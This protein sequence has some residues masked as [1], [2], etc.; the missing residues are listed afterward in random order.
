MFS[1]F[2]FL[3]QPHLGGEKRRKRLRLRFGRLTN[4][5]VNTTTTLGLVEGNSTNTVNTVEVED[6]EFSS[7]NVEHKNRAGNEATT[8]NLSTTEVSKRLYLK[9]YKEELNINK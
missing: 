3:S 6:T 8:T 4:E 9:V 2:F 7:T 5:K 1:C